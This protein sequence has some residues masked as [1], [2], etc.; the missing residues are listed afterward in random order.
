MSTVCLSNL[1]GRR[2]LYD[3]PFLTD[4]R[5]AVDFS[6]CSAFYLLGQ[7]SDFHPPYIQEWKL[8]VSEDTHS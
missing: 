3:L 5:R 1:G 2:L 6:A 7:S 4:L 8:E